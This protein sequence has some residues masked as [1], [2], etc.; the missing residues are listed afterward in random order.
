MM[1]QPN[2]AVV[3]LVEDDPG[4]QEL[5]RRALAEDILRTELHITVDGEDALDYLH[6]R[7]AYAGEGAAPRP[8][9]VLLDLNMPKVDGREVL[10]QMREDEALKS[11]PVVVMTTSD[12]ET[13]ILRSYDLGCSSYIT[14]PVDLLKFADVI[15]ELG[16][17]WF[18]LVTLP[19]KKPIG[20]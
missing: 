17:Y 5:T 2:T 18:N 12:Q 15:R 1:Q 16:H 3:L 6:K 10:K 13:D 4:D 7:G 8:D 11:I 14:K 9:L 19:P 20:G